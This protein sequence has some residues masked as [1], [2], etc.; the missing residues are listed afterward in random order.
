M[1][2]LEP[3]ESLSIS[4]YPV[5][6]HSV[7][8][9]YFLI[10]INLCVQSITFSQFYTL[11][12]QRKCCYHLL[13]P[14]SSHRPQNS[15][16]TQ[17]CIASSIDCNGLTQCILTFELF[18]S[19]D[20]YSNNM[21]NFI[22]KFMKKVMAHEQEPRLQNSRYFHFVSAHNY[23]PWQKNNCLKNNIVLELLL[24]FK[25]KSGNITNLL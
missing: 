11:K 10:K 1:A 13:W 4:A 9:I 3:F 8:K 16:D 21:E 17:P 7:F 5:N 14:P 20:C 2:P 22:K 25:T 23:R 19:T 12:G 15:E 24:E 6:T 18:H